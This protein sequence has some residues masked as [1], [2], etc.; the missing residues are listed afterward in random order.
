MNSA[1]TFA[2]HN[3]SIVRG[4]AWH[5]YP[6]PATPGVFAGD[7]P[8]GTG[9]APG[10]DRTVTPPEGVLGF[11]K[12]GKNTPGVQNDHDGS[13]YLVLTTRPEPPA[14]ASGW[15]AE[16]ARLSDDFQ[17]DQ[18]GDR[19]VRLVRTLGRA[20]TRWGDLQESEFQVDRT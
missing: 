10:P 5:T 9:E 20:P 11:W 17:I 12:V 6:D 1:Q 2:S 18:R 4:H 3:A 14:L 16:P 15:S 13:T 19:W 8:F 7:S